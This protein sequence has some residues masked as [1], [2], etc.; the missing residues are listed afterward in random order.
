MVVGGGFFNLFLA[1]QGLHCCTWAFS[2][3]GRPGLLSRC[4]A[5]ACYR[6]GFFCFGARALGHVGFSS[7]GT[8]A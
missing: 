4:G 1:V 2:S 3:C 8:Q 5:Q 7:C 6:G